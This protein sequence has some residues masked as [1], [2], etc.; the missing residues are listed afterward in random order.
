[1]FTINDKKQPP[2]VYGGRE[3]ICKIYFKYEMRKRKWNFEDEIIMKMK[4]K[5][6]FK[7]NV[8]NLYIK[9]KSHLKKI[10]FIFNFKNR[11]KIRIS[12]VAE[13]YHFYDGVHHAQIKPYVLW[14]NITYFTEI[15]INTEQKVQWKWVDKIWLG[16]ILETGWRE[17][18]WWALPEKYPYAELFSPN[19]RKCGPK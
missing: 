8:I 6:I 12:H 17:S 14:K 19:A 2:E 15:Y 16:K 1:M 18:D 5:L 11:M 13:R 4:I 3:I 7:W 10:K 9:F